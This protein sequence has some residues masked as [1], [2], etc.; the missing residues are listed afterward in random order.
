M[1]AAGEQS[2]PIYYTDGVQHTKLYVMSDMAVNKGTRDAIV[3]RL[4]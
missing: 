2:V 1:I 3:T 4:A